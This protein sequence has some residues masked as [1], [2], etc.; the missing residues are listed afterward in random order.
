MKWGSKKAT[1]KCPKCQTELKGHKLTT[2]SYYGEED[3]K[4]SDGHPLHTHERCSDVLVVK[5]AEVERERDAWK[6][7]TRDHIRQY[8][9]KDPDL[10][11]RELSDTNGVLEAQLDLLKTQ[12]AKCEIEY[13]E[14]VD[15]Y[16]EAAGE[17]TEERNL[18]IARDAEVAE[19]REVM[20]DY[21][22]QWLE[23]TIASA[24]P[25]EKKT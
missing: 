12:L 8:M 9:E 21:G 3:G 7:Q 1:M 20:I 13:D 23:E 14:C 11:A 19:L 24:T 25:L 18:R 2:S 17:L 15:L 5:L 10:R 16:A 6:A 4:H 22:M